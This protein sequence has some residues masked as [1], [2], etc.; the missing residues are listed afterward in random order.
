MNDWVCI[1]QLKVNGFLPVYPPVL[2]ISKDPESVGHD[3]KIQLFH[4]E[5]SVCYT[6]YK[7]Q[8]VVQRILK[9]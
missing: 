9:C 8:S 3:K 6:R 4:R 7:Y 2:N 1:H 5:S